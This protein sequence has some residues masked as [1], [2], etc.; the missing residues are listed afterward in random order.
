MKKIKKKLEEYLQRIK[1]ELT[2]HGYLDGWTIRH[3][4]QKKKEVEAQL[5]ELKELEK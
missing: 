3:W 4:K 5:K 2:M 1:A